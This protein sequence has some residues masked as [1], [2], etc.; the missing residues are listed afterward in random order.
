MITYLPFFRTGW[1]AVE[2]ADK[3]SSEANMF[4]SSKEYFSLFKSSRAQT[5]LSWGM[6]RQPDTVSVFLTGSAT[7]AF[8][9]FGGIL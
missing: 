8:D 5:V 6:K 3:L 1:P 2:R 4:V 7:F 9:F